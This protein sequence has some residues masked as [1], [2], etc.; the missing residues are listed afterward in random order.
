MNNSFD[1]N[2]VPSFLGALDQGSLLGAA[3]VL[4]ISQP[5]VGRHVALLEAQL[6]ASLFERTGRGL[7]PTDAALR[8]ADAARAMESGAHQ[9]VRGV[10]SSQAGAGGTGAPGSRSFCCVA[11]GARGFHHGLRRFGGH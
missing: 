8:L 9:L 10:A 5:T 2:L 3:R 11:G 7:A 4:G 6:G 1:W